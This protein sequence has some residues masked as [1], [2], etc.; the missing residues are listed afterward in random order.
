[1]SDIR[2]HIR[3]Q[4]L[5]NALLALL[6]A[7]TTAVNQGALR[8]VDDKHREPMRAAETHARK[9]LLDHGFRVDVPVSLETV[10]SE[11]KRRDQFAAQAPE[12]PA[13]FRSSGE[14]EPVPTRLT[15]V[16][17]DPRWNDLRECEREFL[18]TWAE[19]PHLVA[20]R[21]WPEKGI[22]ELAVKVGQR[23]KEAEA[24]K[25]KD[26]QHQMERFQLTRLIA[27]RWHF[28]DLM[29]E[30]D[31]KNP[32]KQPASVRT[33]HVETVYPRETPMGMDLL[34]ALFGPGVF[35]GGAAAK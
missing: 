4:A 24:A 16:R 34:A 30:Q 23:A 33:V 10:T 8:M 28:A 15:L 26:H 7:N 13:W 29:L 9:V 35:F 32:S 12:V 11:A 1:M 14:P 6:Q 20:L 17:Y 27:W 25:R 22:G 31:P 18:T 21:V 5:A 3:S 19:N 2:T